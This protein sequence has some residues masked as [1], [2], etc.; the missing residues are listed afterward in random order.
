MLEYLDPIGENLEFQVY[1]YVL[2]QIIGQNPIEE[3]QIVIVT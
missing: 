1:C 2:K 3:S